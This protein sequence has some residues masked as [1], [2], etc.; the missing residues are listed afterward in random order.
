MTP[1]RQTRAALWDRLRGAVLTSATLT[2][3]ESFSYFRRMTGL[4]ADLDVT[5]RVFPS[6]FDYSRQAAL[7]LERDPSEASRPLDLAERQG[8]RLKALVDVTRG[9]TLVLFTNRRDMERVAAAVGAHVEGDDIMVLAQGLHGSAAALADEFRAH[10]ATILLGVDTLWTGQDFPG[11]TLKCLVIAK[12]PF[13]R[14]D[15]LFRARCSACEAA[16]VRWFEEFYLPEAVLRFRQGFGR[17]IRSE[18]DTGVVIVLDPRLLRQR[19]GRVFVE[20]LPEL[21]IVE[22]APTELARVV[23]EQLRRLEAVDCPSD[24]PRSGPRARPAKNTSGP[25]ANDFASGSPGARP[26]PA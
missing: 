23:D 4:D 24:R 17:L 26:D 19:Y 9:R 16:G 22:A 6:P 5:E 14:Q 11:D 15:P 13:P 20:S 1:A 3:G 10:P 25:S 7:V 18:T 12:L 2:V 21:P 8:E